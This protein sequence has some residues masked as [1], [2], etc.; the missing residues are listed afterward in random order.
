MADAI[1]PTETASIASPRKRRLSST[2]HDATENDTTAPGGSPVADGNLTAPSRTSPR[3]RPRHPSSTHPERNDTA[4]VGG[5]SNADGSLVA[6]STESPRQPR[7]SSSSTRVAQSSATAPGGIH[8]AHTTP[9][10]APSASPR[11]RRRGSSSAHVKQNNTIVPG[12]PPVTDDAPVAA[13]TASPRKPRRGSSS[14]V[15]QKK[16]L[17]PGEATVADHAPAAASTASPRKS[18]HRPPSAS[19]QQNESS[20]SSGS[21]VADAPPPASVSIPPAHGGQAE[22]TVTGETSH[23]SPTLPA[24]SPSV[25]SS[26]ERPRSPSSVHVN[27]V[28]SLSTVPPSKLSVPCSRTASRE[29][30]IP[31]HGQLKVPSHTRPPTDHRDAGPTS[32]V[33]SGTSSAATPPTPKCSDTSARRTATARHV[34]QSSAIAGGSGKGDGIKRANTSSGNA[35]RGF[36]PPKP[37]FSFHVVSSSSHLLI[38]PPWLTLLFNTKTPIKL[39]H[40]ASPSGF[41]APRDHSA[42]STQIPSASSRLSVPPHGYSSLGDRP[43][44]TT[45]PIDLSKYKHAVSRFRVWAIMLLTTF[46]QVTPGFRCFECAVRNQGCNAP[47]QYGAYSPC[48]QCA[49]RDQ[50]CTI[51]IRTFAL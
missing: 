26:R 50:P 34:P 3:K 18:R 21:V 47:V 23:A 22:A 51:D 6:A 11:K 46:Q 42:P 45:G 30:S 38:E 20:A 5:A 44:S 10:G 4:V 8:G 16:N 9:A 32:K 17:A 24:P 1:V 12:G 31:T 15:S 7:G 25:V 48:A 35:Q 39:H 36:S 14:H 29:L 27:D 43:S 41:L 49:A 13:S 28:G 37:P 19:V 2:S 40:I 33:D